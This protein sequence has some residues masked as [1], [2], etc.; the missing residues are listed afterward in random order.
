MDAIVTKA[1]RLAKEKI[2]VPEPAD[3]QAL[4]K[5]SYVAQNPTD[6][7]LQE[8]GISSLHSVGSRL[9][10]VCSQVAG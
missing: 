6:G 7:T 10:R 2:P 9:N 8:L 4:V 1:G 5:I 3:N